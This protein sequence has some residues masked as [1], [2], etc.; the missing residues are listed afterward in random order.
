MEK[1]RFHDMESSFKCFN[2]LV[3]ITVK[4]SVLVVNYILEHFTVKYTFIIIVDKI[5]L[6]FKWR[7]LIINY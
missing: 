3:K 6:I 7:R 4:K 5:R 2:L 1:Y